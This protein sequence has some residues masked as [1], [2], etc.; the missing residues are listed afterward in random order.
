ML[1]CHARYSGFKSHLDRQYSCGEM[2]YTPSSNGG[3]KA[4]WFESSQE[5]QR[6]LS[7]GVIIRLENGDVGKT[8][9]G[10]ESTQL[11]P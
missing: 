1:A 8:A 3:A 9:W 11:P 2:A 4:Y 6:K 10:F 7:F 5:Y